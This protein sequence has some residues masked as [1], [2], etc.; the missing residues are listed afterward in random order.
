M[1]KIPYLH[2]TTVD[3]TSVT[4]FVI[5]LVLFYDDMASYRSG[6][7]RG[8]EQ[9]WYFHHFTPPSPAR[10]REAKMMEIAQLLVTMVELTSETSYE[11]VGY[12]YRHRVM[13]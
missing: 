1:M 13:L 10:A 12:H 7:D 3:S 8:G 6:I 11:L 2:A 9:I 4:C 5:A